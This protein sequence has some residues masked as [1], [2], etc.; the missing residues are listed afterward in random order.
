MSCSDWFFC[1]I[2]L[3]SI[4]GWT[5]SSL[6]P[7]H[8]FL[9][10]GIRCSFTRFLFKGAIQFI[11]FQ[12]F[13]P[14]AG[15]WIQSVLVNHWFIKLGFKNLAKPMWLLSSVPARDQHYLPVTLADFPLFLLLFKP[16]F[17]FFPPFVQCGRFQDALLPHLRPHQRFELIILKVF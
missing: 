7:S 15:L 16:L 4:F 2:S 3:I 11:Y 5:M 1:G 14:A 12:T 8:N 13:F 17:F 6:F 10:G 9:W